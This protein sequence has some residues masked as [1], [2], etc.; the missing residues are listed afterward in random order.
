D[1]AHEGKIVRSGD[2][3]TARPAFEVVR[4]GEEPEPIAIRHA[5]ADRYEPSYAN[6]FEVIG[7]QSGW[8]TDPTAADRPHTAVYF[9]DQP[10]RIEAG[11]VLRVR[12]PR[13]TLGS[14]R[15]STSPLAPPDVQHP[16]F[17][18]DLAG[19]LADEA[20]AREYYLRSTG[21]DAEAFGRLKAI[22]AEI[23]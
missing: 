4:E 19:R 18:E 10:L 7:V 22:D 23:L 17:P 14:I 6:G 21:D 12:L 13:N 9:P 3:A 16:E 5:Q 2:S 8:K 11:A 20:E 15:L 1:P